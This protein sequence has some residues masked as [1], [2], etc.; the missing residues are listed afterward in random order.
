[1]IRSET[2]SRV[3]ALARFPALVIALVWCVALAA[4]VVMLP[5]R[6]A[7]GA[8]AVALALPCLA[9]AVVV[10]PAVVPIAIA[11]ALIGVGR[12]ELPAVDPQ[13]SARAVVVAGQLATITGRVA[14]DS[15]P[16]AGGSEVLVEPDRVLIGGAQASGIGNLMVRWRGPTEVGFGDR[17]QATGK[18]LLPRDLPTFD[19]R[20]YLAQ[21][22]VYLEVAAASFSVVSAGSGLAGVP[23]WLRSQYTAALDEAL[24]A[25]HASVLLGVV[26][27]IRQ[28]IPP[29][30]QTALIA[31]G[32]VHLLVLSGL[33]VAVFARIVQGALQPVLGRLATWPAL[34]LI[35][36]YALVGGATPAATRA[37]IMGG[38]AIAASRLGRPT[39][40]WTSLAITAAAMLAWHPELAWDVGFQLSFAGTASIIL[41]TPSI[42]GRLR[43]IPAVLREPFA[44]TCAAQVGTLP[45]MATDFHVLSPVGPLANAMVLPILPLLVGAGLL[46]GPLSLL[47]DIARVTAIPVAALLAYL[48]QVSF[49]LARLPAAAIS[50][51]HFPTW[52]GIAYYSGIGPAIA[53]AHSAGRRR[54]IAL[55]TAV[56]APTVITGIAIGMWANAPPQASVL[57]VGDGQAVLFRGPLGAIL[58]DSGPSPQRL[59]DELGSQLPPWETRLEAVVITAPTLGHVGG[60]AGFDRAAAMVVIPAA[61]MSGTA[62]RSVVFDASARG[63]AV[64]RMS[65]GESIRLAGFFLE[66]VAPEPGAP[67]DQVGAAYLG[68]RVVA[69]SGR[70]LCDLSDLDVDA[71]TVAAARLRG[72]CTYLLL[73]NG[74]RSLPSPELE[75]AAGPGVQMIASRSGGRLARGFPPTVLR[76]DQEGTITVGM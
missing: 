15:R 24:P 64:A 60:F 29:A 61:Q 54:A 75:R 32:L 50:V 45:M 4:T 53:G 37:A 16:A 22:H 40:V 48:E 5:S 26:L 68:L 31:T 67:G 12:A 55:A 2:E 35:G 69:P 46:L 57:A 51:P 58:I 72:T 17:V 7:L 73:P 41:L 28:G 66:S 52:C 30:L 44:V 3:Q 56:I 27:G 23:G 70:S 20:A 74:G 9:L 25:P 21:R 1:V 39:H 6:P 36:V 38:L 19:R 43:R 42:E 34:G 49:L 63:A 62:W 10:R 14:D 33:K 65:A 8:I 18:L 13:T 59:K 76:T 71:Q 47:P 11:V